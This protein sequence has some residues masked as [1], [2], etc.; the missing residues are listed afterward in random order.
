MD[1]KE[2]NGCMASAPIKVNDTVGQS[3]DR[4]IKIAR[5]RV[6]RLCIA[7]AKAEA[8]GIL[9]FPQRF[10]EDVAYL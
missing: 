3:L 6:E 8:C 9:D 10:I 1:E 7:K 5:E 4:R 2:V